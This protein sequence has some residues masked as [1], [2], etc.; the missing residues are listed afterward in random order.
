MTRREVGCGIGVNVVFFGFAAL[1]YLTNGAALA[2]LVVLLLAGCLFAFGVEFV[3]G[4]D[5]A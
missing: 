1:A 5:E 3:R 2:V 4:W